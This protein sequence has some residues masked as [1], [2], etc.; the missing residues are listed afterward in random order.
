[1]RVA[2]FGID[3]YIEIVRHVRSLE[4]DNATTAR[5]WVRARR[6]DAGTTLTGLVQA[7]TLEPIVLVA[8]SGTGKTTE[9]RQLAR[10]LRASGRA[11]VFA[12]AAGIVASPE[13]DLDTDEQ[14][15][16]R[17]L[18]ESPTPGVLFVDALDEL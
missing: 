15:A 7:D 14:V 3:D 1:V 18:L 9:F 16:F 17:R 4:D 10:R 8:P 2:D 6:A 13:M 12:E 11:A 5:R